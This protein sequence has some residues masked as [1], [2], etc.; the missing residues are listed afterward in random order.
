MRPFVLSS[1]LEQLCYRQD[2]ASTPDI[3]DEFAH[4]LTREGKYPHPALALHAF[5]K[6][7]GGCLRSV[8]RPHAWV[9][10]SRHLGM[11]VAAHTSPIN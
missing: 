1:S 8:A 6:H 3:P 11:V 7:R 4:Q 9:L 5:L 10:L 2:I